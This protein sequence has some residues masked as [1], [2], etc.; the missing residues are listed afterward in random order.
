MRLCELQR[1]RAALQRVRVGL[2]SC[3]GRVAQWCVRHAASASVPMQLGLG[4]AVPAFSFRHVTRSQ[5]L[6]R[7]A[8]QPPKSYFW[9]NV[10]HATPTSALA[11]DSVRTV[12]IRAC[13]T[14]SPA[15]QRSPPVH[16]LPTAESTRLLACTPHHWLPSGATQRGPCCRPATV[17][18]LQ[19]ARP[20]HASAL[21]RKHTC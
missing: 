4:V 5:S 11:R 21:Q 12:F 13:C 10:A 1:A 7:A 14:G 9:T 18:K 19:A 3:C 15:L 8:W 17:R 16:A 6:R 20:R 2:G